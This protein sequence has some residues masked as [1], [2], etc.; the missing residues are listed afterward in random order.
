MRS[1]LVPTS[2]RTGGCL[3]GTCVLLSWIFLHLVLDG[4]RPIFVFSLG[5][6]YGGGT[7]AFVLYVVVVGGRGFVSPLFH[8]I[9]HSFVCRAYIYAPCG[10]IPWSALGAWALTWYVGRSWACG[11]HF[12]FISA[13]PV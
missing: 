3:C 11:L 10:L 8:Y 4:S 5:F 7:W 2:S 1:A 6:V 9:L 12:F 13:G